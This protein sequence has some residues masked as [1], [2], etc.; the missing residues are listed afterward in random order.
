M[1]VLDGL[2]L[3]GEEVHLVQKTR[4]TVHLNYVLYVLLLAEAL[5]CQLEFSVPYCTSA[6]ASDVD[7]ATPKTAAHSCYDIKEKVEAKGIGEINATFHTFL[8]VLRCPVDTV[9]CVIY[10]GGTITQVSVTTVQLAEHTFVLLMFLKESHQ[11]F[12]QRHNRQG[13]S[14]KA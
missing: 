1:A 4:D 6:Y 7:A 9:L 10:S 14:S 8:K 3:S 11:K 13:Q 5:K 12:K 2:T